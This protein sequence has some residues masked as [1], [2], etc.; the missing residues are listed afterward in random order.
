MVWEAVQKALLPAA[1]CSIML[2]QFGKLAP[3]FF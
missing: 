2:L 3:D 1:G